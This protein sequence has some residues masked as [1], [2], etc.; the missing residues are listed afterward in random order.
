VTTILMIALT[1]R[2]LRGNIPGS[3]RGDGGHGHGRPEVVRWR[4]PLA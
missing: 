2:R 1:P 4:I 3:F